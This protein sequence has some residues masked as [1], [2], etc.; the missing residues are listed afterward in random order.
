MLRLP[1]IALRTDRW[2]RRQLARVAATATRG[3]LLD[4]RQNPGGA[5]AVAL[6]IAT[7]LARSPL[8]LAVTVDARTASAAEL[9]AAHLQD[10][11]ARIFGE[12]T[13]GKGTAAAYRCG[14]DWLC[15][16][17]VTAAMTRPNGASIADAGVRPDFPCDPDAAPELAHAWLS[18]ARSAPR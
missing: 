2:L 7:R 9:L 1:C 14:P 16:T 13:F 8:P 6:R 5:V 12:R 10:R 17:G 15:P 18:R 11:G 3:V 4:L